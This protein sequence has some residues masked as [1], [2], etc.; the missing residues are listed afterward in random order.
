MLDQA[1]GA[2]EVTPIRPLKRAI[3][4]PPMLAKEQISDT[5]VNLMVDR[6][7]SLAGRYMEI[8]SSPE[9][10][11]PETCKPAMHLRVFTTLIE[12]R[13]QGRDATDADLIGSLGRL[14]PVFQ[15]ER[16]AIGD[17]DLPTIGIE[18][19]IDN[20]HLPFA[21]NY[22]DPT[23]LIDGLRKMGIAV[24]QEGF[25]RMR[26]PTELSF[27]PSFSAAVQ[28]EMLEQLINAGIIPTETNFL[29]LHVNLGFQY[30]VA[31]QDQ[32]I[33]EDAHRISDVITYAY[34]P[35]ERVRRRAYK[36]AVVI[37]NTNMESIHTEKEMAPKSLVEFRTPRMTGPEIYSLTRE[38]QLL[39]KLLFPMD[40]EMLKLHDEFSSDVD[41]MLKFNNLPLNAPTDDRF[42]AAYAIRD[43]L[44]EKNQNN[45][46]IESV[47]IIDQS[48]GVIE[49]FI[50]KI[51]AIKPREELTSYAAD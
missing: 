46:E 4:P 42:A 2:A 5:D 37:K 10:P 43:A 45:S 26:T 35:S 29:P 13:R 9:K 22:G 1:T 7:L 20:E 38:I 11:I 41:R 6:S 23:A 32:V 27:P 17:S 8:A 15:E 36:N 31:P 14:D 28:N 30:K 51:I 12:A 33:V 44:E 47:T 21:N 40:K 48:K 19:E 18:V 39:G 3:E 25:N 16:L 50:G 34:V 24:S 49:K